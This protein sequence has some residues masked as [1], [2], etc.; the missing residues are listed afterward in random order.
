MIVYPVVIP[1][2][3]FAHQQ[4]VITE[5]FLSQPSLS[6][7]SNSL[8][9]RGEETNHMAFI[10]P[11]VDR[12]DGVWVGFGSSHPLR[13]LIR[14]VFSYGAIDVDEVI[15]LAL[16]DDRTRALAIHTEPLYQFVHT[17]R[18]TSTVLE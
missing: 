7:L 6:R 4:S 12:L 13:F 9:A 18:P 5:S 1:T 14:N 3:G 8:S 17:S 15:L 2:A 10:I 11:S 16:G